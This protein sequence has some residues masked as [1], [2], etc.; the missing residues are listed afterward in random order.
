VLSLFSSV[1]ILLAATGMYG[2]VRYDVTQ[3]TQEIGVRMAVG[4]STGVSW[5]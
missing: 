3:R 2:V 4:A 1:A 5:R